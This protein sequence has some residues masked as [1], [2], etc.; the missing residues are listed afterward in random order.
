M[1]KPFYFFTDRYVLFIPHKTHRSVKTVIASR[2]NIAKRLL[3]FLNLD[4]PKNILSKPC[5]SILRKIQV[6]EI[7]L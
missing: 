2:I 4:Y 3:Y 1:R 6:Q 5:F 7:S